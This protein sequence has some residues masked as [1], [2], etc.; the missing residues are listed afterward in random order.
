[1]DYLAENLWAFWLVVGLSFLVLEV[2]TNALV[3]I[4]FVLAAGVTCGLSF[5]VDSFAVQ[6]VIFAV[7]SV[8]FIVLFRKLYLKH[9]KKPEKDMNKLTEIVGK[10]ATVTE[11][12][13]SYGGRVL[14]GDVYWRAVSGNGDLIKVGE[15]VTVTAVDDT[16][17]TVE[18][19]F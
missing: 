17:L 2:I 11:D 10:I 12:T 7:L 4:W 19:N 1:M 18:N 8:I 16:T 5:V 6:A 15:K 9:I 3:S 13:D 14:V